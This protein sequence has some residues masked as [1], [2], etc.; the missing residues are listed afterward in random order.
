MTE[1]EKMIKGLLYNPADDTLIEDRKNAHDLMHIFNNIIPS[2]IQTIKSTLEK[3]LPN[4]NSNAYINQPFYCDYGYNIEIGKNFFANYNCTILDV[5]KVTIGDNVMFAPNVSIYTASHP[6]HFEN[7][8]SGYEF[9]AEVVIGNNVWIGGNSVVLPGVT[10][11]DNVVIGAG[12]VVTKNFPEN[13][14]IGGNPAKIIR[15]ITEE[16]KKYYFKDK[17]FEIL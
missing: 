5:S 8:N 7:R 11:G 9:G 12:S 14:V 10:V 4:A 3:L 15:K 2:D 17:K 1:K 16:D 13:C 6:I